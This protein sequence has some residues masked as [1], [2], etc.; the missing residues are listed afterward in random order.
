M[1][2]GQAATGRRCQIQPVQAAPG[3]AE[4][5][6]GAPG[7]PAALPGGGDRLP[8]QTVHPA[9]ERQLPASQELLLR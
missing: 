6:A 1:F 7:Q 5:R 2:Q 3:P 4:W 9:P 8:G